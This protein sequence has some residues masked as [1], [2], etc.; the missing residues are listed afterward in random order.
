MNRSE[1]SLESYNVYP[2]ADIPWGKSFS[3]KTDLYEIAQ[4]AEVTSGFD[5]VFEVRAQHARYK[6]AGLSH[7]AILLKE[8]HLVDYLR[9][10]ASGDQMLEGAGESVNAIGKG[11]VLIATHPV[12]TLK[13]VGKATG[14]FFKKGGRL[15]TREKQAGVKK[16][17]LKERLFLSAKRDVANEFG[18]D[19]Y[20]D[21]PHLQQEL[22]RIAQ[23]RV[24]G[25]AALAVAK[26]FLPVTFIGSIAMTASGVSSAAD[27]I[28]NTKDPWELY[29]LNRTAFRSMGFG[30]KAINR[31][32][33]ENPWY[34]PREQT[35]IRFYLEAFQS[36][37]GAGS[38]LRHC[39]RVKDEREADRLIAS[40]EMLA[41]HAAKNQ[42]LEAIGIYRKKV[43]YTT[44]RSG[45]I[46]VFLPYDFF[47][48]NKEGSQL[49]DML[50]ELK[51][52]QSVE[53]MTVFSLGMV[54]DRAKEKLRGKGIGLN[55]GTFFSGS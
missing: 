39:A 11:F 41:F 27:R 53:K 17:P 30:D 25:K 19:F 45:D 9:T 54:S 33:V 42:S 35:R 21:N 8:I 5:L 4:Q 55:E 31:F 48:L 2:V 13:N 23:G 1:S 10:Q 52:R 43:L 38:L 40:L 6:V 26:F 14:E 7:L 16:P 20:S 37:K 22:G 32:L 15:F 24:G 12:G 18:A 3:L 34:N 36:L 28:A 44:S 46:F 29:G 50:G 51:A 47:H 49:V